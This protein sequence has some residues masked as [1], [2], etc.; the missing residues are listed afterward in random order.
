M[1]TF[2]RLEICPLENW[3]RTQHKSN[4]VFVISGTS[5]NGH[6]N[7]MDT[8]NKEWKSYSPNR[9]HYISTSSNLPFAEIPVKERG[10]RVT[11]RKNTLSPELVWKSGKAAKF[12][13]LC[14]VSGMLMTHYVVFSDF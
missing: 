6:S 13:F 9:L 12:M 11:D 1:N 3:Y 8:S 14:S 5:N 10:Q 7:L 2:K 4:F